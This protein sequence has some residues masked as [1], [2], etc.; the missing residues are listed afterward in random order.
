MNSGD[1]NQLA[2][3]TQAQL[4]ELLRNRILDLRVEWRDNALVLSGRAC[5]YFDKQVA[6]EFVLSRTAW[7]V[8][9]SAITLHSTPTRN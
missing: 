2:D 8:N 6:Q 5:S 9:A 7:P 3:Q 1:P 4:R